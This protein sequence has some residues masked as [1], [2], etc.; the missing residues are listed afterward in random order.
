MKLGGME[1]EITA[2]QKQYNDKTE[3]ESS[4]AHL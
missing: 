3:Q 2:E 1:R 4:K